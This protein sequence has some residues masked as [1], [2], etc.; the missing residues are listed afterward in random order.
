[1]S[2][3]LTMM[4]ASSR[5]RADKAAARY[6]DAALD[7]PVFPLH[8]A[9]FDLIAEIKDTS[10]A[11]GVLACGDADRV[12][13]AIAYAEGGAAAISIL[14]EPSRFAGS[15]DHLDEV[16]TAVAKLGV[17][18]MRKD[19]LVDRRQILE[20][21]ACGASGVLLIAAMLSDAELRDMLDCALEHSLFVLLESFDSKDLDRSSSL[22]RETRYGVHI[23]NGQLLAG[24]N[25]RNLRTLEV[26]PA[27]LEQLSEQLPP[28]V[29]AVAESGQT[30]P[31][32][33]A[34]VAKWGYSAALVG[35]ALMRSQD[36]S[37][38]IRDML[39]AGRRA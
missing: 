5:E 4:A 22:L 39:E 9:S 28:G 34:Q 30:S 33:I 37:Q 36:P 10:P 11:E 24:I 13:R 31:D 20:A 18:V 25:T 26:D 23:D 2:D 1:M 8:L 21:K 35:T 16:A 32:D 15:T 14:T 7:R 29:V 38:L 17:P 3:F 12:E 27:R 6:P 19:F